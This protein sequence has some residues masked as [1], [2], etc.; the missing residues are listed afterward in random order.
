MKSYRWQNPSGGGDLAA[1]GMS[2]G[3]NWMGW[4]PSPINRVVGTGHEGGLLVQ[5]ARRSEREGDRL[6]W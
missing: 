1:L 6:V 3:G 4:N 2:G 5:L